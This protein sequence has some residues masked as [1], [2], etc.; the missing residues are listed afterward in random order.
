MSWNYSCLK[1]RKA[2]V[3]TEKAVPDRQNQTSF[4]FTPR[5]N[6]NIRCC[7]VRMGF[8][9]GRRAFSRASR[10]RRVPVYARHS[11]VRGS[12]SR[13]QRGE[14]EARQAIE[15]AA[16]NQPPR[17]PPGLRPLRVVRRHE[18]PELSL[19]AALRRRRGE[20]VR[21]ALREGG[22]RCGLRPANSRVD[23]CRAEPIRRQRETEG[24][25]GTPCPWLPVNYADAAAP[26]R[27]SG[28]AAAVRGVDLLRG[29]RGST[30]LVPRQTVFRHPVSP[31]ISGVQCD[32]GGRRL[33]VPAS[34]LWR[35]SS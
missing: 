6:D 13:S 11:R 32:G 23:R 8:R 1:S 12:R 15:V 5:D 9:G 21:R 19:S 31:R 27:R 18:P 33:R 17:G 22:H 4:L 20:A 16:P 34:I 26:A 7:S 35:T 14:Q 30:E 25:D 24:V 3:L 29:W 10:R 28:C 2:R